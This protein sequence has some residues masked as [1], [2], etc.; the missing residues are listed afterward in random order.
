MLK[1]SYC[2]CCKREIFKERGLAFRVFEAIS[3]YY[4]LCGGTLEFSNDLEWDEE[5]SLPLKKAMPILEWLEEQELIV[6]TESDQECIC[7][8]PLHFNCHY[9]ELDHK[10]AIRFCLQSNEC[11]RTYVREI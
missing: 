8:K 11:S 9:D 2:P 1:I 10:L 4:Y 6:T 3:N 7:A 5:N